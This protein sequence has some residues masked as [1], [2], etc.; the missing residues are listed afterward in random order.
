[1]PTKITKYK[2][3]DGSEHESWDSAYNHEQTLKVVQDVRGLIVDTVNNTKDDQG[4]RVY[5]V[6]LENAMAFADILVSTDLL[7]KAQT[8]I[9]KKR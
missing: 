7:H 9:S 1:M 5:R 6:D 4:R 8:I 2:A 3:V